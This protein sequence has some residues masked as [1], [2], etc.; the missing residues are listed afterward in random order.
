MK[1]TRLLALAATC[2]A[3]SAAHAQ[4]AESAAHPAMYAEI[5]YAAPELKMS[6][7]IDS[8]KASPSLFSGVFG[9]QFHPNFAVEGYL[10]LG[11]GKDGVKFNGVSVPVNAKLG[12]LYGVFARPSVSV[13]ESVDLFARIGWMST[14]LKA[15]GPGGSYADRNS[16]MAY[17]VGANFNLSKTAYLQASWTS[18]YDK[19]ETQIQGLGLAY[20]MRF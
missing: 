20:G 19:H 14:E 11:A 4:S 2:F 10:G 13:S 6:D 12:T 9:Y 5:G 16:S 15:S 7:G 1:S 18:F 17:G 8:M 3:L